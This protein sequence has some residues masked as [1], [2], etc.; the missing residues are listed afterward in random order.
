M[1]IK[2]KEREELNALSQE[3]FGV[4]TRWQKMFRGVPELITKTVTETVPGD[5]GAP[6]TTKEVVVADLDEKGAKRY[7]TR[8]YSVEECK[9]LLLDAKRQ[10]DEYLAKMKAQQ[11]LADLQKKIQE[12]AAGQSTST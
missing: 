12:Q 6:E 2:R 4:A 3:V 10:R 11:E 5:K 1:D 9:K 7:K 8:T